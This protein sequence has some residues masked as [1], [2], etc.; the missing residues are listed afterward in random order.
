[1]SR[2][3]EHV[4]LTR[5]VLLVLACVFAPALH[6]AT[7]YVFSYGF[8]NASQ[9]TPAPRGGTTRGAPVELDTR[10]PAAYDAIQA[11]DIEARERDARAIRAL[12]GDYRATFEFI[13]TAALAPGIERDARPYR[14]WAT[15]RVF[16]IADTPT[17]IELQHIMVM[18]F[19]DDAGEISA[20]MVMK[21]WRQRWQWQPATIWRYDGD[22]L[23]HKHKLS[24]REAAGR[25]KQ[26]VYQVDDSLRYEALGRWHYDDGVASWQS[27]RF[28]RPLRRR[29]SSVRDDYDVLAGRHRITH[30]P[31]GWLHEQT[32]RKIAHADGDA[33]ALAQE[34][35][36]VRYQRI[37]NTDFQPAADYWAETAPFWAAVRRYWDHALAQHDHL[38]IR[39][40]VDGT[41][42]F[43]RLFDAADKADTDDSDALASQVESLMAPYIDLR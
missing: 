8:D 34:I 33:T 23:W 11:P 17:E 36:L 22:R 1:M 5:R 9:Q 39:A 43:A 13:E 32:A 18:R 30:T 12:A 27:E 28:G 25:W 7:P 29:E 24:D 26:T 37:V 16:V 40:S 42:L 6:A 15:E 31:H 14:S 10:V 3:R 38:E 4:R 2:R 21:H 20:P 41:P 19:I 35:G